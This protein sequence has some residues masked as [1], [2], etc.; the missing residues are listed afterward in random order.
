LAI[1]DA[2]LIEPCDDLRGSFPAVAG[3][4]PHVEAPKARVQPDPDELHFTKASSADRWPLQKQWKMRLRRLRYWHDL[5]H[6]NQFDLSS[7]E[8]PPSTRNARCESSDDILHPN[9]T[10]L[11]HDKK[12]RAIFIQRMAPLWRNNVDGEGRCHSIVKLPRFRPAASATN[13]DQHVDGAG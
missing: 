2:R 7:G 11:W 6:E 8:S 13:M 3:K 12:N 9:A 5:S 1:G 4:V 10:T